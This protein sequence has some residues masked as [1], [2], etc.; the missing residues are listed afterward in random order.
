MARMS[1]LRRIL[2]YTPAA[3]MGILLVLW[4]LS[5]RGYVAHSFQWNRYAGQVSVYNG[6]A[7]CT[8]LAGDYIA[9]K[10]E[11]EV[12]AVG[13]PV[14]RPE[15]GA[16]SFFGRFNLITHTFSWVSTFNGEIPLL[17]LA[18]LILPVVIGSLTAFRF[19]LWHYLGYTALVALELANYLRW[20]E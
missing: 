15:I 5:L 18:T 1:T 6:T 14:P 9:E 8:L 16:E 19:R 2:K 20:Q 7:A 3:L 11:I 17:V 12:T 10:R 4:L 13:D